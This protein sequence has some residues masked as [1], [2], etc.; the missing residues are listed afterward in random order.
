MIEMATTTD[1]TRTGEE[2]EANETGFVM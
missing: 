1:E 2:E